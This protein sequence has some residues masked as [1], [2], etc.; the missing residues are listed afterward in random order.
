[1]IRLVITFL[2]S[3]AFVLSQPFQVGKHGVVVSASRIASEVGVNILK[4]GGNAVDAAVAV[5]FALAVVFPEAGNIGGGGF[6]VIRFPNGNSTTIDYREKAP[7]AAHSDMYLD[8]DGNPIPGKSTIGALSVGIPGSVAGLYLASQK[9]GTLHWKKLLQPAIELAENGFPVSYYFRAGLLSHKDLMV[10]FPS[11]MAMFFKSDHPPEIGETLCFSDLANTLR[12]IA[13]HGPDEFYRGKTAKRIVNT[14]TKYSGI[15]D[16]SDMK[17][18]RA[19]EREPVK[20]EYRDYDII[21]MPPPSSGGICLAEILKIVEHFP[22]SEY[23]FHSSNAIQVITEAE[24]RVYANRAYFIGDPDFVDVPV[25]FLISNDVIKLM[26]ADINLEQATPSCYINHVSGISPF[27]ESEQTTHFSIV[28]KDGMAVANTTTLNSGYGSCLV[29]EGTGVLLN[30]EMDDFSIKPGYPNI[31]G[32]VGAEANAIEPNKRMLS[33][34]TPT[35]VSRNDSLMWILG[36]PGGAT[37]IT[38]VA[39]VIV[40]LIDFNMTLTE[41]VDMPRFHHQWL[42]DKLFVEKYS[43]SADL[44]AILIERGY[45]ILERNAIGDV[46]A[47][48]VDW[49]NDFYIGVPDKRRQSAACAY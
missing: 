48:A 2:I 18:Y 1:M 19:I 42:P 37:I 20:F 34:M 11:T 46:N 47:I 16:L 21:S 22:L 3:I 35:I 4:R 24:R 26:V 41:A 44:K 8:K 36:T 6:M 7:G 17:R 49:E 32:L 39:Q 43:I 28:D 38:S 27:L 31:Y 13:S 10:K 23:G 14:V 29:A 40:N 45:D 30:N 12:K 33:S 15:L 9:Y 5:G 25:D